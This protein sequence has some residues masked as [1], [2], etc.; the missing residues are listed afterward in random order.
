LIF[1][2]K[3]VYDSGKKSAKVYSVQE[4]IEKEM[5]IAA[6]EASTEVEIRFGEALLIV[7]GSIIEREEVYDA[8][9][10]KTKAKVFVPKK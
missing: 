6:D 5:V 10:N 7:R 1:G 3:Q 8:Q 4:E 2:Y 9:G